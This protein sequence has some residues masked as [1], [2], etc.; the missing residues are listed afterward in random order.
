MPHRPINP[1]SFGIDIPD[2]YFC[3]RESETKD[4]IKLIDN[5]FNIILKS[6]RRIG[7]SSLVKH[8]LNQKEVKDRYNTLFVDIYG[9]RDMAEFD[10]ELQRAFLESFRVGLGAP[11][12]PSIPMSE[13]FKYLEGT[14][15]P[16]IVVF[17]EFQTIE[18]YPEKAAAIIRSKVQGMNNTRFIFAGSA[19]HMLNRMFE[20]PNQP[21]YRSSSSIDL[22][23]IS[24]DAYTAFCK[25]LFE[26]YGK[27]IEEDAIKTIYYLF[28]GKTYDMQEV[29][30]YAFANTDEGETV[31]TA[32]VLSAVEQILTRRD[33]EFREIMRRLVK[34]KERNTV[35]CIADMGIATGLTST[36]VLKK[37]D[38]DNASTVQNA[39]RNI[40][41]D[42][43][44]LVTILGKGIYVLQDR[45]FELWLAKRNASFTAKVEEAEERFYRQRK[46]L[47][48]E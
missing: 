7:K 39:L 18:E 8:V 13:V 48:S 10:K 24:M 34:K 41:K 2:E 33:I 22:D 46:L 43:F 38:L 9:T 20:Y 36:A 1:F 40:T 11:Q 26:E 16:N 30:R 15:R 3:D 28:I 47:K 6:P 25:G 4:I 14:T 21:F 44:N 45:F 12:D 19:Q 32:L 23:I 31:S 37:Y 29:M 17:D 5:G 27:G 35:L 42:D